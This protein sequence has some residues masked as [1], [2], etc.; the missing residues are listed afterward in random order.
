MAVKYNYFMELLKAYF[1]NRMDDVL[2]KKF[3][4]LIRMAG[5]L[6]DVDSEAGRIMDVYKEL[7][8]SGTIKI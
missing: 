5:Y 1:D 4:K 8:I 6:A 2:L 7:R 3:S